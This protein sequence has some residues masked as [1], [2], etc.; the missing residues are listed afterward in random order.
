MPRSLILFLCLATAAIAGPER[1]TYE[2]R[3]D[4]SAVTV[5]LDRALVERVA[6]VTLEPGESTIVLSEL[7]AN[8]WDNSLQVSGTG[9]DG[10]TVLDVQS[11]NRF[12]TAEPSPE[13]RQLEEKLAE[14]RRQMHLLE[15]ENGALNQEQR[16]L[17]DI[18]RAATTVPG[19]GGGPR[20]SLDEWRN[21]LTFNAEEGRRIQTGLRGV[22]IQMSDL[23]NEITAAE[24][25]LNE[26]RGRLPGQRAVKQ[27]EVR[28][29]TAAP[30]AVALTVSYTVPG[31]NWTPTYRARLDSESRRVALDYQ[32]QVINRTGEAWTDVALTLSTARPAAG[33]AAPAPMPWI[34]EELQPYAND[35]RSAESDGVVELQAFAVS[36]RADV[37]YAA[38]SALASA[39]MQAAQATVE[40]GLTSASFQVAAPA[41]IPADGT[42]H[43][44][45]ITTL[46]L[47][48]GLR[49]DTTPKYNAAAFLTAKVTNKSDFPLLGGSMASFVD[50]AFIANSYLTSTMANEEFELALGGDDAVGIERTLINRFV[51]KTG[52]TN[53]GHRITYE[54]AIAL[55]N[56]HPGPI[57]LKLSEPLPVSRHE[58]IVVKVL[59]PAA[60][61]I[62]GPDDNSAFQRD[63]QGILTWIGSLAPGTERTLEL[64]FSIEHPADMN[65]T[66]IE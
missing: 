22:A 52:F 6:Q 37:G 61:Q 41:S 54:Y 5:F 57:A 38:K 47:P 43:R 33:G 7:P 16:V 62:G 32:A 15:D 12:L 30:G 44:V 48:A 50:G 18:N 42:N 46:N 26:T 9:P 3:S 40:T 4:V 39:P 29:A 51:E 53:S 8:L 59:E 27:V 31:A 58:K 14:L 60:R 45:S 20:P 23:Q 49:H 13:I 63:E 24:R 19:E 17:S 25:Q 34:V 2:V 64:K 21:L 35:R 1:N 66:G 55:T 11:R 65:V 56:N 10:T 28:V 36:S